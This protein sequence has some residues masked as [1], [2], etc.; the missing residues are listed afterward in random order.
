MEHILLIDTSAQKCNVGLV[1]DGLLIGGLS[2]ND[3]QSQSTVINKMIEQLLIQAEF[4]LEDLNAIAVCSGPGSYTGLRIGLAAAKGFAFALAKP[5]IMQHKLELLTHQNIKSNNNYWFYATLISAREGEFFLAIYD[6]D[7]QIIHQPVHVFIDGARSLLNS[8]PSHPT[9]IIG[10]E[11]A[12]KAFGDKVQLST[13]VDFNA[14]AEWATRSF[15]LNDFSDLATSIPFYMKE[16][17]IHSP[18][19]REEKK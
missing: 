14:W 13:E 2:H 15:K 6:A 4:K 17:F 1:R 10:D 16:V 5:L 8:L 18:R 7:M 11:Q 12:Q 19:E 9:L 3:P